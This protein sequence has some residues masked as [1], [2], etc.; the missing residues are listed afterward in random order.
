MTPPLVSIILPTFNRLKYLRLSIDSVFAQT[1]AD[2]ELVIADDGSDEETYEYLRAITVEPR[3]RLIRL[4]H[5]G[6]PSTVRNLALREAR[7]RYVAFL[8]SDDVWLPGKLEAQLAAHAS[9][10]ARRWSYTGLDLIDGDGAILKRWP[11][12]RWVPYDGAVFEVLLK[13]EASVAAPAVLAERSLVTEAGGFDEELPFF[14]D[15]DMWMRLSRLSDVIVVDQT[16]VLVRVH[17]EHYSADKIGRA[18]CRE[19]V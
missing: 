1:H 15:Y 14:E 16:L 12:G 8:D 2:W 4:S 10:P 17:L 5:S 18:S 11:T 13:Q 19:R 7:G 6:R 3:I 9:C